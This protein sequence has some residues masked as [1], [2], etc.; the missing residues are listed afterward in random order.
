MSSIC[1]I[2]LSLIAA[3]HLDSKTHRGSRTTCKHIVNTLGVN[4]KGRTMLIWKWRSCLCST[5]TGMLSFDLCMLFIPLLISYL[6][7]TAYWKAIVWRTHLGMPNLEWGGFSLH[8][9]EWGNILEKNLVRYSCTLYTACFH[10]LWT[11]CSVTI[12]LMLLSRAEWFCAS[13]E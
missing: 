5:S 9:L 12:Y 2:T 1:L 8:V 13:G 3:N 10:C 7:C 6:V 11:V 4:P